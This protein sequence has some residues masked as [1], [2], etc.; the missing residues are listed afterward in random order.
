MLVAMLQLLESMRVALAGAIGQV[1][2]EAQPAAAAI[3][4]ELS[5]RCSS[6]LSQLRGITAM[7]RMSARPAPTRSALICSPATW[8]I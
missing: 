8:Q 5:D 7:Y 4:K 3:V 6:G 1:Q 2:R